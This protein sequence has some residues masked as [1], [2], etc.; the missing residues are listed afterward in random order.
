MDGEMAKKY[1]K[2]E[3]G[4]LMLRA[5]TRWDEGAIA[6]FS[7]IYQALL[8]G[9]PVELVARQRS[10]IEQRRQDERRASRSARVKEA[11]Q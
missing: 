11:G 5:S 2:G 1:P 4:E 9:D 7:S 10:V 3:R 8:H 6:A